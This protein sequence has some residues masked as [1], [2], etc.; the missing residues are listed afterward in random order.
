MSEADEKRAD[1]NEQGDTLQ[2]KGQSLWFAYLKK[3]HEKPKNGE[4]LIEN[5]IDIESWNVIKNDISHGVAG[6][7]SHINIGGCVDKKACRKKQ[8]TQENVVPI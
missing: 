5:K 3:N 6:A 1:D 8:K 7:V 4:T 2:H